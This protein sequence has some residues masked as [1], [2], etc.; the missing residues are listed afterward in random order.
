MNTDKIYTE[1]IANEYE[2]TERNRHK[3]LQLI[4]RNGV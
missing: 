4:F 1:T 2:G 3:V